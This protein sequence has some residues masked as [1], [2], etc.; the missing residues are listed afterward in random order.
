MFPFT[1]SAPASA[2][3]RA[4]VRSLALAALGLVGLGGVL[5][6]YRA[7]LNHEFAAAPPGAPP[8]R[9]PAESLVPR[10]PGR[11]LLLVVAH[12]MCPCT[13]A[14]VDQLAV[15][16]ARV[17]FQAAAVV[18]FVRHASFSEGVEDTEL[19]QNAARIP[20][21]RVVSD[22]NGVEAKRFGA[23][24]SGQTMLYSAAGDLQFT[25]GIT[26]SRGHS[27]DNRGQDALVALLS[28]SATAATAATA[29]VATKTATPVYGCDLNH[30][31]RAP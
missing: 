20:G 17:R 23:Y 12:P 7:L 5:A 9:W 25:G 1:S 21:V 18:V 30:P 14:T 6:G 24:G 11:P 13:R 27:G 29:G 4:P 15:L 10:A 2:R 8:V 3:A 31:E 26:A 22:P 28:L 19:W 16:M